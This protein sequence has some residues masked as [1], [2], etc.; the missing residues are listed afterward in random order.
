M[1]IAKTLSTHWSHTAGAGGLNY[2]AEK[3]YTVSGR[4]ARSKTD[5]CQK[6]TSGIRQIKNLSAFIL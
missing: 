6:E 4:M 5:V 3:E 2:F 1:P